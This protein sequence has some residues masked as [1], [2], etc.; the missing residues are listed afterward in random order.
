[1]KQIRVVVIG[2]GGMGS[3]YTQIL[4][5]GLVEGMELTG[6][7]CRNEKGQARIREK[8]PGTAIYK[9]VEDT[10]L[11]KDEF[12]AV[13]I[14]TPHDTHVAISRKAFEAGKHVICDKPAGVSTK[15]VRG[16]LE[17]WKKAGTVFSMI[18]NIRTKPVFQKVKEMIA[19]GELGQIT[20][21]VWVCNTWYRSACYHQSAPWRSTWSGE[22]GGLLINQCQHY[23][24]IWQWLLGMPDQVDAAIDF[25]KYNEFD[26]DDSVDLRLWYDNGIRGTIISSSGDAPGTNRFEI[27]GSKGKL[28]IEHGECLTFDENVVDTGIFHQSNTEIYGQPEHH[29]RSVSLPEEKNMYQLLFQNVSDHIRFGTP[30]LCSGED[31]LNVLELANSSYLSAWL[32]KTIRLPMD[33]ELYEELLKERISKE[34]NR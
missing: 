2:F 23:L 6:I 27:W 21:A 12:D 3:Q 18:F 17:D 13:M 33:D 20:R 8:Y 28:T 26:V 22:R 16:L 31:G 29:L 10:F 5:D 15:E 19:G 24:D 30:L 11:H 4:R 25:G 14:V 1:M 34:K 7:C 9:D 32:D